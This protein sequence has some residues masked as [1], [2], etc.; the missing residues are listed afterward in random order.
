MN[1][2]HLMKL[3]TVYFLLT[4]AGLVAVALALRAFFNV[5]AGGSL[6]IVTVI[7]P[8]MLVG[9]RYGKRWQAPPRGGYAWRLTAFFA[10]ISCGGAAVMAAC[11]LTVNGAWARIAE[12]FA[13][14]DGLFMWGLLAGLYF[15]AW[16]LARF[17][18]GFGAKNQLK[19]MA[20]QA[21]RKAGGSNQP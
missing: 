6:V 18:F 13:G 9:Q 1:S 10:A 19:S 8:A 11:V 3:Y 20:E 14:P 17:F 5:E 12:L 16:G 21:A 4:T 2:A 7:L 15:M